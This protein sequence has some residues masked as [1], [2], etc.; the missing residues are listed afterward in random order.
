MQLVLNKFQCTKIHWRIGCCTWHFDTV[1]VTRN[2]PSS[3][4]Q[5]NEIN[6]W[7]LSWGAHKSLLC[8]PK[9]KACFCSCPFTEKE[10]KPDGCSNQLLTAC[11][12]YM[13]CNGFCSSNGLPCTCHQLHSNLIS[14][15]DHTNGHC[16][17]HIQIGMC[18]NSFCN[19]PISRRIC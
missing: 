12:T 15:T 8:G 4:L 3:D 10:I 6:F 2:H 17:S 13:C 19:R 5:M 1:E 18:R 9:S 7:F 14:D 11:Y 16:S